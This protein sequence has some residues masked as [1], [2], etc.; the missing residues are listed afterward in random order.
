MKRLRYRVATVHD[1]GD[2]DHSDLAGVPMQYEHS[3]CGEVTQCDVAITRNILREPL[4]LRDDGNA[5]GCNH[6]EKPQYPCRE[7]T[8]VE[9]GENVQ[10]YYHALIAETH[11]VQPRAWLRP[12]LKQAALFAL[13]V[14]VSGV[15]LAIYLA[16][17]LKFAP[18]TS[19]AVA[20]GGLAVAAL[21]AAVVVANH[22]ATRQKYLREYRS[23]FGS[24]AGESC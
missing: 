7:F 12:A 13:V 15:V 19:G 23:R 1:N 18:E 10:D 11:L 2:P 3:R 22:F 20:L 5:A 14:A 24:A 6:C 4:K 21:A 9:T 8:W 16:R 17:K